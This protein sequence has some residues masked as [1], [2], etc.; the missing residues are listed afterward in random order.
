MT[1]KKSN[2]PD[3]SADAEVLISEARENAK[4]DRKSADDL[5]DQV[6]LAGESDAS[7]IPIISEIALKALDVKTRSNNQI[8]Q[9]AQLKVKRATMGPSAP[10]ETD[11]ILEE[12][13]QQNRRTEQELEQTTRRTS[14]EIVDDEPDISGDN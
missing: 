1:T 3:H 10:D 2:E 7:L 6:K 9:L 12:I 5:I 13:E 4:L 8:I 11:D 14:F